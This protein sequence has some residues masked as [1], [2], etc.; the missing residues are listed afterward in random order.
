VRQCKGVPPELAS[1]TSGYSLE[2]VSVGRSDA[3]V[4]RLER[5]GRESLYLKVAPRGSPDPLLAEKLR[6][7]WIGDRLPV[8]QVRLFAEDHLRQYLLLSEIP[9]VDASRSV[10]EGNIPQLVRLLAQGLR[11]IHGLPA[12]GCPFDQ[13]LGPNIEEARRRVRDGF[14][15][16]A[17]FDA[18]RRGR[19]ASDLFDELLRAGPSGED[20]TFT[21]GDYC[22]PNIIIDGDAIG[23]FVDWGRAGVADRYQDLALAARSLER[24]WGAEW[25]PLLFREYGIEM[26]DEKKIEFYKLLDEF[27]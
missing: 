10:H 6:L 11:M 17:D 4:F 26:P 3:Q 1:V 25:V 21:H 23:G 13:T 20:L 24:N 2:R 5:P 12:D 8:P 15:D 14:V 27:F 19:R 16:E 22:L 7:E 18:E 9:G